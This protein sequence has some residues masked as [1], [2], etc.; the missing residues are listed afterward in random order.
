MTMSH[1][2]PLTA[3]DLLASP[4]G[5]SL[6]FE[7]AL[8][9]R[10]DEFDDQGQALTASARALEEFRSAVFIAGYLA[11][12]A[13]GAAV[14]MYLGE[15][16]SEPE[17]GAVTA[18]DVAE[19]L[20]FVTPSNP[21]QAELEHAMAEVIG[22]AMYWQPPHGADHVAAEPEVREALRPFAEGAHRHRSARRVVPSPRH[23]EPM[24]SG[25]GR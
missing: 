3:E 24:G 8:S 23:G 20:R 13:K 11:D 19:K 2:R 22:G 14:A 25:L 1:D 10:E 9:G 16:D 18:D 17:S 12:R 6:V 15:G 5:R 21:N 7:L 4:R